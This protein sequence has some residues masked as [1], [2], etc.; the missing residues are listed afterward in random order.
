MSSSVIVSIRQFSLFSH[1]RN[2]KVLV[3]FGRIVYGQSHHHQGLELQLRYPD[4]NTDK[5]F[6]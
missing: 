4:D 3:V 5:V 1:L 2:R 6:M